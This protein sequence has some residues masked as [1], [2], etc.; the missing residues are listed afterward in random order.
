VVGSLRR[1][2]KLQRRLDTPQLELA[3][4]LVT[5]DEAVAHVHVQEGLLDMKVTPETNQGRAPRNF[6]IAMTINSLCAVTEMNEATKL[7]D[8]VVVVPM[9]VM[10]G[11]VTGMNEVREQADE[12]AAVP[13]HVTT[14]HVIGKIAEI[15][16][17]RGTE[18]ET[19]T[20]TETGIGKGTEKEIG[21][22]TVTVIIFE[23]A[24]MTDILVVTW[25]AVVKERK[26]ENARRKEI[27]IAAGI[28]IKM[29]TRSEIE[30]E[31]ERTVIVQ[32][33]A[34]AAR[35]LALI[36]LEHGIAG[37]VL[38]LVP[39]LLVPLLP[40]PLLPTPLLPMPLL[41]MPLLPIPLLLVSLLHHDGGH[42]LPASW[43]LI[44]TSHLPVTAA[45][46]LAV[47]SDHL[48]ETGPV[49]RTGIESLVGT[50]IFPVPRETESLKKINLVIE[51]VTETETPIENGIGIE[52]R[53]EIATGPMTKTGKGI[54][55]EIE[56]EI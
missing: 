55:T 6:E 21:I 53:T 40:T 35:H 32:D 24:G 34:A 5:R 16:L 27:E 43:T 13:T 12:A 47:E 39:L 7:V 9:S 26:N 17:E 3:I 2:P 14:G 23:T 15:E 38:L 1:A 33:P 42:G 54:G 49:T 30:I 46:L 37:I 51:N 10:T 29:L 45:D 31:I 25:I 52:T 50:G 41:P 22:V 4:R 28:R 56:I 18:T 44:G 11:N 8:E 36:V 20:E 19:E 48:I